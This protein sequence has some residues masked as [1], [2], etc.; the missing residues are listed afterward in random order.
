MRI[1]TPELRPYQITIVFRLDASLGRHDKRQDI[2]WP[3]VLILSAVPVANTADRGAKCWLYFSVT[4]VCVRCASAAGSL[5]CALCPPL[6]TGVIRTGIKYSRLNT[7]SSRFALSIASNNPPL[8]LSSASC[9]NIIPLS[10]CFS[11][12]SVF[13]WTER[14][15]S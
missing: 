2:C 3:M 10:W 5:I 15:S 6:Q 8:N 12:Y 4:L 13:S 7:Y 11:T 14:V 9:Q 1:Q